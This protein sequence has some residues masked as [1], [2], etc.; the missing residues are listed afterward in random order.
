MA[1][2]EQEEQISPYEVAE[3]KDPNAKAVHSGLVSL[4]RNKLG[5]DMADLTESEVLEAAHQA[6]GP[7]MS[8]DDFMGGARTVMAE[9]MRG[10][11][12]SEADRR[13]TEAGRPTKER[14]ALKNVR[15]T[16][17]KMKGVEV[18]G[19]PGV[20]E[21]KALVNQVKGVGKALG[22]GLVQ[23]FSTPLP[24]LLQWVAAHGLTQE[25]V[26]PEVYN[27]RFAGAAEQDKLEKEA[28][29]RIARETLDTIGWG[30]AGGEMAR[31]IHIPGFTNVFARL[32]AEGAGWGATYEG[33]D[34]TLAG[35]ATE[36]VARRTAL[37]GLVGAGATVGLGA[38]LVGLGRLMQGAIG[39]KA[40]Q[41]A[42]ASKVLSDFPGDALTPGERIALSYQKDG[43]LPEQ[44]QHFV[45]M[46]QDGSMAPE[47]AAI[48]ILGNLGVIN[49]AAGT[50]ALARQLEPKSL[51]PAMRDVAL[52]VP[53][54]TRARLAKSE[55]DTRFLSKLRRIAIESGQSIEEVRQRARAEKWASPEARANLALEIPEPIVLESG[56]GPI[57]LGGGAAYDADR[58]V[59]LRVAQEMFPHVKVTNTPR[60]MMGRMVAHSY[61]VGDQAFDEVGRA[62]EV[63]GYTENDKMVTR[64]QMPTGEWKYGI[65]GPSDLSPRMDGF[66]AAINRMEAGAQARLASNR[67]ALHAFS[68]A[69]PGM[70]EWAE[71]GLGKFART[72]YLAAKMGLDNEQT[73]LLWA[74]DMADEMRASG[75]E[76]GKIILLRSLFRAVEENYGDT[77]AKVVTREGALREGL[78]DAVD[79]IKRGGWVGHDWYDNTFPKLVE[80][81][82]STEDAARFADF[83][84]ITSA[85]RNIDSNVNL[86]LQ[87]FAMWQTG[88]LPRGF[89]PNM[90]A[91]FARYFAEEARTGAHPDVRTFASK[92]GAPKV[93]EFV[94]NV[95]G[96]DVNSV[97][98]DV[99]MNRYLTGGET[100]RVKEKE[101]AKAIIR[102][103]A[104]HEG[105]TPRQVQAA[106]WADARVSEQVL[107]PLGKGEKLEMTMGSMRPYEDV[108][109]NFLRKRG[110][111]TSEAS[112]I[113]Q[114]RENGGGTF[115]P[116][117][118]R[119]FDKAGFSV[120]LGGEALDAEKAM[121]NGIRKV[122]DA[123][124]PSLRKVAEASGARPQFVVGTWVDEGKMHV[125]IGVVVP[126]RER[127]LLL[128]NIAK[129]QSIGELG[130]GGAF[131]GVVPTGHEEAVTLSLTEA[132]KALKEW[133]SAP[134]TSK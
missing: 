114:T 5:P 22:K 121:P 73:Y 48:H 50:S 60:S 57:H 99:W 92:A 110:A 47:E 40:V 25:E 38:P 2:E 125:E 49:D 88:Q 98:L 130:E 131:V 67:G 77:L 55:E 66:I 53:E 41:A 42:K 109:G 27:V 103:I 63:I 80:M 18:S 71:I 107:G 78:F 133:L 65:A 45:R 134:H 100:M 83:L 115:Y 3:F 46:S 6:Y 75:A 86:A 113:K 79:R 64:T 102:E 19:V 112:I 108:T 94:R 72:T 69:P 124:L 104:G 16:P 12:Q 52:T 96:E 8:P 95:R 10:T 85:N 132:K 81:F 11:L 101:A 122:V 24:G 106:M 120:A 4:I 58:T 54:Q 28:V 118:S 23:S 15:V 61:K 39:E 21:R 14:L 68:G 34:A 32:G 105:K 129:Q 44:V 29:R 82:G 59:G 33:V 89:G 36:E 62:H 17:T 35:E 13:S 7:D 93:S 30:I 123:F 119:P 91:M 87:S 70:E 126:E 43:A 90:D 97:T 26:A 116:G 20:E 9:K 111:F 128:G 31:A 56:E 37:G 74:K 76:E 84:A 117:T 51:A 1:D 127:A